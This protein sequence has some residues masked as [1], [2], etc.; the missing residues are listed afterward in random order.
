MEQ[1]T[2]KMICSKCNAEITV[3]R[4][5]QDND[6]ICD[7]CYGLQIKKLIGRV[8]SRGLSLFIEIYRLEEGWT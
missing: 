8:R 2:E 5:Y 1:V 4:E 3:E 6:G 7:D